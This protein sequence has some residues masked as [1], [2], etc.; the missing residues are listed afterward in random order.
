MRQVVA[1]LV[2]RLGGPDCAGG[3]EGV[4]ERLLAVTDARGATARGV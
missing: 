3:G 2:E 1:E 4:L